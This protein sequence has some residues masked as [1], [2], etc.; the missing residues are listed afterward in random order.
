M[1]EVVKLTF[2]S[3]ICTAALTLFFLLLCKVDTEGGLDGDGIE[4]SPAENLQTSYRTKMA[5][6]SS[7]SSCEQVNGTLCCTYQLAVCGRQVAS[8]S[9]SLQVCPDQ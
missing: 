6:S 7:R 3:T 4:E 9:V 5:F 1:N 8:T 2:W